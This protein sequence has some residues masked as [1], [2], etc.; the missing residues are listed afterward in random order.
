VTYSALLPNK[1]LSDAVMSSVLYGTSDGTMLPLLRLSKY[2]LRVVGGNRNLY[3]DYRSLLLHR[4][5]KQ[6][7][8]VENNSY[9]NDP[10]SGILLLN[11]DKRLTY[12]RQ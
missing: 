7:Q 3:M 12:C 2:L 11:D 8:T 6:H 10:F 5:T 9:V 1:N 4:N